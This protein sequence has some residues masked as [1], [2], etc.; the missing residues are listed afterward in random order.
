MKFLNAI[1]AAAAA[2]SPLLMAN[3]IKAERIEIWSIPGG[4]PCQ[5][6]LDNIPEEYGTRVQ[7]RTYSAVG[8]EKYSPWKTN[9][10]VSVLMND[11]SQYKSY[12]EKIVRSIFNGCAMSPAG[13]TEI[14]FSHVRGSGAWR[15]WRWGQKS[16][17]EGYSFEPRCTEFK[18]TKSNPS[19]YHSGKS[20][21]ERACI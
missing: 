2:C 8:E 21:K 20:W 6:V 19:G 17:G 5:R 7:I 3:P 13:I 12:G 18:V 15:V 14:S 1:A 10:G 11:F 16:N 4:A 9:N